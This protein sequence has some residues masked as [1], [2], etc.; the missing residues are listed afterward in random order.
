MEK[1]STVYN[2]KVNMIT[3]SL[4]EKLGLTKN[5]KLGEGGGGNSRSWKDIPEAIMKDLLEE[6]Q[7]SQRRGSGSKSSRPM[8]V[9]K[10][11]LQAKKGMPLFMDFICFCFAFSF[12]G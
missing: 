2:I 10:L 9:K 4:V 7:N 6:S 8:E 12:L 3:H 1:N 5:N 11:M